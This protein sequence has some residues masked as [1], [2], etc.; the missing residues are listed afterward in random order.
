V[1][2]KWRIVWGGLSRSD[3]L[4]LDAVAAEVLED[5]ALAGIDHAVLA[6][7][8]ERFHVTVGIVFRALV[9]V[10]RHTLGD[11][12]RSRRVGGALLR[13]WLLACVQQVRPKVVVTFIDNSFAFQWIS[14]RY[15][16]ARFYAVQN[17]ARYPYD[18]S[19][20]LPPRPLPGS[21]IS[22]PDLLCWGAYEPE[23]YARF[24]HRIDRFHVVGSLRGARFREAESAP[25]APLFDVCLVSQWQNESGARTF[26]EIAKG[27]ER[28]TEYVARYAA[29]RP[30]R[31]CVAMR[32]SDPAE[33]RF[34]R[35]RLGEIVH[36]VAF[37]PRAWST[38]R[39]MDQS[40]VVVSFCS[41]AATEA[42]GWGAKMVCANLSG[43]NN[44]DFPVLGPWALSACSYEEFREA[45]DKMRAA[46]WEAYLAE[47]ADARAYTMAY[48]R[49]RPAHR[50]LRGLVLEAM[51][52]STPKPPGGVHDQNPQRQ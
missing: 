23:L 41:S 52:G 48:D 4:I 8:H 6:T 49:K 42:F 22:M 34:Y 15:P 21:V 25:H 47:S 17:G 26:P 40:E 7:R 2:G 10:V 20:W 31:L 9:N 35:D 27:T 13:C 18:V 50:Y 39:A 3:V 28:I 51:G 46:D 29:D 36:L 30:V 32:S 14:R 11:L 19:A 38:Y 33:T 44:Y 5:G 37:E 24:G 12:L 43:H 45:L 1:S 16:Y